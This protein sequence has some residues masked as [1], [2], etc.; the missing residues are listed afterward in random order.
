M[1]SFEKDIFASV[2]VPADMDA[3]RDA[4]SVLQTWVPR[5][6]ELDTQVF[7][8]L[9]GPSGDARAIAVIGAGG[10]GQAQ[11]AL[12]VTLAGPKVTQTQAS[13][14]NIQGFRP[15]TTFIAFGAYFDGVNWIATATAAFMLVQIS[16]NFQLWGKTGL[17][18]GATFAP[19]IHHVLDAGSGGMTLSGPIVVGSGGMQISQIGFPAA[20]VPSV[21]ANV[22]D[23]YEEGT[24]T[25]TDASGASLSLAVAEGHYV[26]IGQFVHAY[27]AVQFPVTVNGAAVVLGGLPFTVLDTTANDASMTVGYTNAAAPMMGFAPNNTTTIQLYVQS[28]AAAAINSQFSNATLKFSVAYRATA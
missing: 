20:Q 16:G 23:D 26:K 9:Q 8:A 28:T 21:G 5:L 14:I 10:G 2:A 15:G 3:I 24:W 4:F 18:P 19:D 27:G 13:Q 1:S 25:P 17:T 12:G 7:T 11:E 22:L 6:R